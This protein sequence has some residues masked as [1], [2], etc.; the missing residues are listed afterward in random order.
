MKAE[1]LLADRF[2]G[3]DAF[4]E[5]ERPLTVPKSVKL[6]EQIPEFIQNWGVESIRQNFVDRKNLVSLKQGYNTQPCRIAVFDF[7][8]NK[9]YQSLDVPEEAVEWM[10][11]LPDIMT[12]DEIATFIINTQK[13]ET[14]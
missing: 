4:K 14:K 13:L 6:P 8:G 10:K 2:C 7:I 9:I 3:S 1:Q 5:L 12:N 11:D